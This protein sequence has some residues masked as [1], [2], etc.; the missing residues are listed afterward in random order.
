[1]RIGTLNVWALPEPVGFRVNRR[2]RALGEHLPSLELDVLALQEVWR[3][4]ARQALVE[5][6]KRAGLP[7][8]W[9]ATGGL[10][11]GG[12]LLLSRL[13]I[14]DARF[15]RYTLPGQPPRSEHVDYY[16]GKGFLHMRLA[17]EAGPFHVFD[18]HLHA[19]YGKSVP[20]EYATYRIGQIVQL[21][22]ALR[23]VR[24]PAVV[25]GDFNLRENTSEYHILTGLMGA[26]DVASELDRRQ[27]TV[28]DAHPM[29][30][31]KRDR[32]IDYVFVRDS[33]P[34]GSGVGIRPRHVARAFDETFDIRGE[35]ASFSNHAGVVAD[36]EFT[37]TPVVPPPAPDREA[38]RLAT[39]SLRK[40]R[41]E[42][43]QRR[44]EDRVLAG[45]GLGGAVLAGASVR[46]E[47]VTRRRLLRAS[48]QG[49]ACLALAPALGFSVLSEV[50]APEEMRAFEDLVARL[51]GLQDSRA[52]IV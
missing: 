31:T 26:R 37:R 12:L 7:Y 3:E 1:M 47:R 28:Y 23:E 48:L 18:T 44:V 38:L 34:G 27:P 50:F 36:L 8:A 52:S 29:R 6:G 22:L 45:A 43:S 15:E 11:D 51:E 2:M 5:A 14:L 13:P 46:N 24:E 32:R 20:H 21:A 39:A 19:R 17:G 41:D 35:A 30:R 16:A 33:L 49:A 42:T 9:H 25:A 40:G 10:R 4:G